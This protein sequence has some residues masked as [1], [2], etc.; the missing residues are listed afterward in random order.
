MSNALLGVDGNWVG[1][2][3]GEPSAAAL[4]QRHYSAN[5]NVSLQKRIRHGMSGP[6][7]SMTLLT[8]K[9]DALFIWLHNTIE[10]YDRQVGVNCTVFRN[11]SDTLASTLIIEASELAWGRWPGKRLWT[12]VWDAKVKSVNPGYCFKKA[13]WS[14]C[15]R[16]KDGRLTILELFPQDV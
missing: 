10:R 9:R 7:E 15:G 2:L 11:E 8:V 16:N 14:V 5:P 6:G 13:G 4:Y 1:V 12:Y 3:D